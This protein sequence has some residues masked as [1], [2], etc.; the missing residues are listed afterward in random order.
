[1]KV[2]PAPSAKIAGP[3]FSITLSVISGVAPLRTMRLEPSTSLIRFRANTPPAPSLM[4][5]AA[6]VPDAITLRRSSGSEPPRTW[7][8]GPA[9]LA[10]VLSSTRRSPPA[11]TRHASGSAPP[12]P[13][14]PPRISSP[15]TEPPRDGGDEA[16]P[17]RRRDHRRLVRE[18]RDEVDRPLDDDG[19]RIGPRA[20]GQPRVVARP[21]QRL[22]DGTRVA[23]AGRIDHPIGLDVVARRAVGARRRS[24]RSRP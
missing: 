14:P 6:S 24:L 12:A 7:I 15:T 19:L 8:A 5:A 13:L 20:D 4:I 17:I 1:M 9:A 10:I 16:R 18:R 11:I 22:A 3:L 2:P 23:A 21:P